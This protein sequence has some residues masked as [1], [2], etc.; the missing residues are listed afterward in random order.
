MLKVKSERFLSL[1]PKKTQND[2][3][4]TSPKGENINTHSPLRH[5]HSQK[6]KVYS[7]PKSSPRKDTYPSPITSR[8]LSLKMK[9]KLNP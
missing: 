8:L 4:H 9:V 5:S 1:T 6:L 2:T 7:N 3:N